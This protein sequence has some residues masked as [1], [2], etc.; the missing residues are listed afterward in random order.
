MARLGSLDQADR[1]A[2]KADA[3]CLRRLREEAHA[4]HARG[5]FTSKR[6]TCPSSP[7]I[8]SVRERVARP[9]AHVSPHG[10]F[11]D[12]R[13]LLVLQRRRTEVTAAPIGVLDLRSRTSRWLGRN[14]GRRQCHWSLLALQDA[15][16]EG[17]S[18]R[19]KRSTSTTGPCSRATATARSRSCCV[20]PASKRLTPMAD[21]PAERLDRDVRAE[22]FDEL[23]R[24][25]EALQAKQHL[26]RQ[27]QTARPQDDTWS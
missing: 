19:T 1:P 4:R 26:R 9:D 27:R 14:Q 13:Q 16:G 18:P 8:M 2:P 25:D 6:T 15:A 10:E 12:P 20:N 22:R 23:P 7:R 17:S 5:V 24:I 3:S 11:L 21:P